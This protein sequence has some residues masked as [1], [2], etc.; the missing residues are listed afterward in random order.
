MILVRSILF[1]AAFYLW[2][3]G[4]QRSSPTLVATTVALN[5][6]SASWVGHALL[7]EA[8]PWSIWIGVV[9]ILGGIVLASLPAPAR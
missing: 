2:S 5:P 9:A 6:V 7:G 1:M 3:L 8:L 4:L